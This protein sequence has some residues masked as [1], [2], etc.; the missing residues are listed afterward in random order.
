MVSKQGEAKGRK[1]TKAEDLNI[2]VV[3]TVLT[4]S[5]NREHDL[6]RMPSSDTGDLSETLVGLSGK[7]RGTPSSGNTLESVTLGDT[8]DIDDLVLL[9]DGLDVEGLLE[10]TLGKG[11]LVGDRASVNLVGEKRG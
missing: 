3:E 2:P 4:G 9:E 8:D 7:L 1:N 5:S 11:D 10:V 6:G